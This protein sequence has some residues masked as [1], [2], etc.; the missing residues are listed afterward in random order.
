M[1]FTSIGVLCI[2]VEG[3]KGKASLIREQ[4]RDPGCH[5]LLR[6]VIMMGL[7]VFLVH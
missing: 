4:Y 1:S 3:K 5:L 7:C 6:G 2:S